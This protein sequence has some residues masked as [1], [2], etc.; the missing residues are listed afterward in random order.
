MIRN[1]TICVAALVG[2]MPLA[3][4]ADEKPTLEPGNYIVYYAFRSESPEQAF[5]LIKVEK[6][7]GKLI[8]ELEDSA[9]NLKA[10]LKEFSVEGR[11]VL[12][13][14]DLGGRVLTFEGLV[15][16]KN[17]KSALGSFGDDRLLSRGRLVATEKTK[18]EQA[19]L[20]IAAKTPEAMATAA[21]LNRNVSLLRNK[22]RRAK[23][24]EAADEAKKELE[25]AEREFNDKAPALYSEVLA[26]HADSPLVVDA[27]VALM[28]MA[29]K[30]AK[31]ENVKTWLKAVDAFAEPYGSRFHL[32]ALLKC[33]VALGSQ[34]GFE[35]AALET[36]DKAARLL[37]D[38][39]STD[40][41]VR[42]LKAL[43]TAQEKAGKGDL[44]KQTELRL[45]KLEEQV[46]K[47]YLAKVPP[48]K[49]TKFQG[50]TKQSDRVAVFELFTGAQCPPCVA[51]DVAFDGLMKSYKPTELVLIQYHMHIPGPDPLTNPDTEARWQ[52][53]GNLRGVPSALF[54][55]KQQAEPKERGGGGM[56][57]SEAKYKQY[58]RIIDPILDEENSIKLGGSVTTKGDKIAI[59]IDVDGI[60]EASD[61]LKL[62]LVLVEESIKYPGGNGIRF[63]HHVVRAM[64]GGADGFAIKEKSASKTAE[65]DLAALRKS[66]KE[67][68][69]NYEKTEREFANPDKP[70]AFKNLRVIAMLQDD[71]TKD[72]LHAVQLEVPDTK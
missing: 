54:N 65:V 69:E 15:D 47:E 13:A 26:R 14:L 6:K 39:T 10:D 17:P 68:L 67:Y 2:F 46:D 32:D 45:V 40:T 4:A 66:L 30:I 58:K 27:A 51:A 63:H 23:A 70:L 19:D 43:H 11:S 56:A 41:Q 36:A 61:H 20:S 42:V 24:G 16:A 34:K 52:Y 3:R 37:T 7:G 71:G 28:R 53:Y 12:V 62:R 9:P 48:F 64:P 5:S 1:L 44:A 55:G 25:A 33:A 22:L 72:I 38:K 21:K 59:K 31:P 29:E 50:R 49:P 8:A 18:L 60:K 35:T 57:Q